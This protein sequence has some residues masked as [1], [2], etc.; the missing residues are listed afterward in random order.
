[1]SEGPRNESSRQICHGCIS[2]GFLAAEV[3]EQGEFGK[4]SYCG[5]NGPVVSLDILGTRVDE[6]LQEHFRLTPGNPEEPYELF[7]YKEGDWERRGDEVE[8]IIAETVGLDE[9][10]STDLTSLLSDRY[11]YRAAKDGFENP[12]GPEAM[13]EARKVSGLG[14]R[15]TWEEFRREIQRR[16]RFFNANSE[17]LLGEI[18]GDLKALANPRGNPI[19][20]T[21]E[22]EKQHYFF[23]RGRVAESPQKLKP[24]L[25]SPAQELGPPPPKLAKA[26]RMNAHG[27]SVFY[28]AMDQLTCLSELRPPV[29]SSVVVG[30][31]KVL[32]P[33]TLLDLSALSDAYVKTSYF[34]PDYSSH[35]TRTAF[36]HRLVREISRP[37]LPEDEL[38]EYLPTQVIA[39][40]LAQ[41]SDP[42]FD[43]IIYPASQMG[44]SADNVV[45]FNQSSR[46]E[47]YVLPEGSSIEIDIPIINHLNED[48][49]L[50]DE[51]LVSETVPTEVK[52]ET[53]P[54]GEGTTRER[55]VEAFWDAL[56]EEP[57]DDR[58][59]ALRLDM[60]SVTVLGVDAATYSPTERLVMRSRQTE[61]ERDSFEQRFAQHFDLDLDQNTDN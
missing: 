38:L 43:G 52:D 55:S 1:M 44:G 49:D 35:R 31:F 17:E 25:E 53:P 20:R 14:F 28:G 54:T 47:P 3:Q 60:D 15:L 59:L 23:W 50:H 7:L 51:I 34:D 4:C 5:V 61:E 56:L 9:T 16:S 42:R 8:L 30:K 21:F 10:P 29:G 57:E 11:G 58:A 22:P 26:G 27:I 2:D 37:V 36:L 24:I 32:Q 19:I 18:F 33:L 48:Y 13:Y 39:E 45:L 46:V 12:Y 40:Y 6:V 41:K